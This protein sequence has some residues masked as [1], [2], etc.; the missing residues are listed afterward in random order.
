MDY[1]V[2]NSVTLKVEIIEH[3]A[4][5]RIQ[6]FGWFY[7]DTPICV[8]SC[9]SHYILSNDGKNLTIVNAS[10]ANVG[11]YEVRVTSYKV[12]EYTSEL[13]NKEI[14]ELLEYHAV[15]APVTYTLSYKSKTTIHHYF[16]VHSD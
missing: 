7:N 1:T 4:S 11:T 8:D 6:S 10:A 5:D 9:S 14:N 2:G 3:Y 16:H 15:L 12:S 13:C